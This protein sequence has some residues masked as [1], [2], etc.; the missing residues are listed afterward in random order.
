MNWVYPKKGEILWEWNGFSEQAVLFY[1]SEGPFS[2][3]GLPPMSDEDWKRLD[4][5]LK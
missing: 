3:G 5:S 4:N 1:L 2:T